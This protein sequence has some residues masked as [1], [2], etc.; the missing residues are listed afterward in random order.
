MHGSFLLC[1]TFT[2]GNPKSAI[3]HINAVINPLGHFAQRLTGLFEVL[4]GKQLT[5]ID[6][7]RCLK[8]RHGSLRRSI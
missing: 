4:T 1:R 2:V 8:T 5:H 6:S 3:V 7:G